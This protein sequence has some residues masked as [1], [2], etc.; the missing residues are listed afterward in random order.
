M[1]R[2]MC[3]LQLKDIRRS[4][5]L[6][7]LGL[8]NIIDKL[9]MGNSVHWYGHVLRKEDG[10]VLRMTLY[11]DAKS[12]RNKRRLKGGHEKSRWRKRCEGWFEKGRCTLSK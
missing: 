10:Q 6:I 9:S 12:Q 8:N 4:K 3:G 2:A 5:D 1:A 11:S 7:L